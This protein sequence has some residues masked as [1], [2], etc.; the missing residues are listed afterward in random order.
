[1]SIL[2]HLRG[3]IAD[4][5]NN[6]LSSKRLVTLLCTILIVIAFFA[7]VFFGYKIDDNILDAIMYIVLGG[8]GFTGLE[9]FAP[10]AKAAITT[11]TTTTT[12]K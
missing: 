8:L 11:T 5:D 9:R 1:M 10:G 6:S 7:N 2:S 3:L 12:T 4:G